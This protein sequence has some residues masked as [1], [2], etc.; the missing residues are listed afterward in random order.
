MDT[1]AFPPLARAY[2]L[3]AIYEVPMTTAGLP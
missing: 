2:T 3:H 1:I